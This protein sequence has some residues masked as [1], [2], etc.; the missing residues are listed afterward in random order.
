[1]AEFIIS[2]RESL[3]FLGLKKLTLDCNCFVILL[4][5][6]SPNMADTIKQICDALKN[7]DT[8]YDE[9]RK[10]I[11]QFNTEGKLPHDCP[12]TY[13]MLYGIAHDRNATASAPRAQGT[14]RG[15]CWDA[16]APC[17]QGTERCR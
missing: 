13:K 9:V 10:L 7:T 8:P 15:R 1:M 4:I 17:A 6:S 12:I 2:L 3:A 14:E 5:H 11:Q 16:S